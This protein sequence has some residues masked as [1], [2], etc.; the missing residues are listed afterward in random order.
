MPLAT[1]L[2]NVAGVYA[3]ILLGATIN[4]LPL[5]EVGMGGSSSV[6]ADVL[7]KAIGRSGAESI[8]LLP[9]VLRELTS[10][11]VL[12]GWAGR[13]LK[14]AAVGG[15]CI[16]EADLDAATAAGIPA[17]QGYGLSECH[18]VVALNRP[19]ASR[20][21]SVGLP[22]PGIRVEVA[23]DGEL[24]VHGSSMIGYLGD[25]P[26]DKRPIHTGDLGHVD[27]DGFVY[28]TGRKKNMFITGFGRN[29]SPEWP[30]AEL[31]HEAAI[32]QAVVCGEGRAVNTAIIVPSHPGTNART[33]AGA[34]A[35]ANLKLPD[36][37][38]IG[39]WIV[40]DKPFTTANGLLTASGKPRREGV[41]TRYLAAG[42]A[43]Q[44]YTSTS[45]RNYL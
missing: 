15:A 8:I 11:A 44:R 13:R 3:P 20:R 42:Q 40:A 45:L 31:L 39:E 38:R 32:A 5:A 28:V 16:S 36:Y 7:K 27:E 30:E 37:A 24:L 10:Q 12:T 26:V 29:V 41:L 2:E 9:Q 14:F 34:V 33:I 22:L 17:F 21:G 18:S 25:A 19:D 1:L 35:K 23:G 4:V 6:N 43:L